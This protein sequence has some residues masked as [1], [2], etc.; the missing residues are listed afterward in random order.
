MYTSKSKRWVSLHILKVG[1]Q[2][3]LTSSKV[4]VLSL[5]KKEKREKGKEGRSEKCK[6]FP[7]SS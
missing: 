2:Q 4:M 6:G 7:L 5:G 1:E 3:T